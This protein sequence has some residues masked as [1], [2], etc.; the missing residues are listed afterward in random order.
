[1]PAIQLLNNKVVNCISTLDETDLVPVQHRKGS[2]MI[3]LQV[4]IELERYQEG[5]G[6]VDHGDQYHEMG[7][8]FASKSNYKKW[9]KRVF[10]GI[11]DFMLLNSFLHGIFAQRMIHLSCMLIETSSTWLLHKN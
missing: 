5:K 3:D 7:A 1:M 9:Y 10:F 6:A 2:E 11:C 8:G 4:E